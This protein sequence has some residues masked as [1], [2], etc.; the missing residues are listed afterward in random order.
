[1]S[2]SSSYDVSVDFCQINVALVLYCDCIV[3]GQLYLK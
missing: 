3:I 2:Y 1:V